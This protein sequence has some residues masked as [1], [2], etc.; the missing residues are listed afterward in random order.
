MKEPLTNLI[1]TVLKS[2]TLVNVVWLPSDSRIRIGSIITLKGDKRK[3]KWEV[4][5]QYYTRLA[6]EPDQVW[7]VGGLD[8]PRKNF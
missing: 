4:T 2:G 8:E 7:N 6:S 5:H 3:V 1:Q